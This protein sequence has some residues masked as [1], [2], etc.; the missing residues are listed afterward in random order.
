[1]NFAWVVTTVC[2]LA[3]GLVAH[4]LEMEKLYKGLSALHDLLVTLEDLAA[5]DCSTGVVYERLYTHMK[6]LGDT[7][8]NQLL[9]LDKLALLMRDRK[10]LRHANLVVCA[11]HLILPFLV[12]KRSCGGG[13]PPIHR[14]HQH[15]WCCMFERS[16]VQCVPSDHHPNCRRHQP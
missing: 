13:L 14:L 1:M 10:G 9:A 3:E 5:N 11:E 4:D 8:H 2:G 7:E 6:E 16:R 12:A 15:S